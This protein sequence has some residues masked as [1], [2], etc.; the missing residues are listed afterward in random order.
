LNPVY[1]F[2]LLSWLLNAS[3]TNQKLSDAF[4]SLAG[5][6]KL[7]GI[8]HCN[9]WQWLA[10]IRAS[11]SMNSPPRKNKWSSFPEHEGDSCLVGKFDTYHFFQMSFVAVSG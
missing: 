11:G 1:R 8:A 4:E 6:A 3:G 2:F 10:A 9:A 7:P 5:S